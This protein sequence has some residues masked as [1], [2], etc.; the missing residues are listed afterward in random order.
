SENSI[1]VEAGAD[2]PVMSMRVPTA[3]LAEGTNTPQDR[4]VNPAQLVASMKHA[5]AR[6]LFG[7]VV[8]VQE[9]PDISE[10]LPTMRPLPTPRTVTFCFPWKSIIPVQG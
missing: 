1:P 8:P 4:M 5:C 3:V 2:E 9:K 6:L 10:P 7:S